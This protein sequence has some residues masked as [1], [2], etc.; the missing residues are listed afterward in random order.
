MACR[1]ANKLAAVRDEIGAA[2]S[3]PLIAADSD[4]AA[5]LRAMCERAS[6]IVTTVGPYQLYG[7][8]LVAACAATGTDYLNLSGEANW[9]R[10]MIDAHEA[11]AKRS[12]ARILFSCVF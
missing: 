1:D 11:E 10:A 7:S 2:G 4:D 9:M 12:G 6:C 8:K 3:T 5:A